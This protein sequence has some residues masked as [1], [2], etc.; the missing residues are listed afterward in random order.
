MCTCFLDVQVVPVGMQRALK[1]LEK[2]HYSRISEALGKQHLPDPSLQ[3]L[4]EISFDS[5]LGHAQKAALR[6]G[7]HASEWV[8]WKSS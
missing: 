5:M 3:H 4:A 2:D 7:G 1:R 8:A 6:L